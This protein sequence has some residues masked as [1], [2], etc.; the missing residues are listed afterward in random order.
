MFS[1]CSY[2]Q[3]TLNNTKTIGQASANQGTG[4]GLVVADTCIINGKAILN[5][6]L[7]LARPSNGSGSD[8]VLVWNS[9]DSLVKKVAPSSGGG[10]T[11]TDTLKNGWGILPLSFNGATSDTV[12]ADSATIAT[13]FVRD[14][15][16][17]A[18]GYYPYSSNPK[19]YL[20]SQSSDWSLTGNSGTV[21]GTNF[22][23]TTDVSL[24]I[25]SKNYVM[26]LDATT[27]YFQIQ[28]TL[29]NNWL[30][31]NGG[32]Y[33]MGLFDNHIQFI[34][35][36]KHAEITA[37]STAING[38][39][40]INDG[41][42]ANGY[43]YTSDVNGTGSWQP[44]SIPVTSVTATAPITSSGGTTPNINITKTGIDTVGTLIS[45]SIGSGFTA[46]DTARTNAV[47]NVVGTSPIT[48]GTSGKTKFIS[49]PNAA[50]D[51]TTKGAA[52]FN[53]TYFNTTSGVATIDAANGKA[54]TSQTGYMR[55]EIVPRNA[56]SL[57]ATGTFDV[58]SGTITSSVD[59]VVVINGYINITSGTGTLQTLEVTFTDE[60][61][62]THT[63]IPLQNTLTDGDYKAFTS[64]GIM[65]QATTTLTITADVTFV[66][67]GTF[68]V[69]IVI[70]G[71]R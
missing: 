48:V 19:G 17:I 47:S 27:D 14:K 58:F 66:T 70:Q 22:I 51:G 36:Q 39:L 28:D 55:A 1:A 44:P 65:V 16:S 4:N 64:G 54:T 49:I 30:I 63:T 32:N 40:R 12:I 42:Q 57:G 13:Y 26:T 3:T 29:G 62:N 50:A 24:N 71:S 23:G 38:L 5:S 15:D 31:G 61:S 33:L 41:T 53:A 25:K 52:A 46:I 60:T 68:D 9:T 8:S 2:G 69:G 37:D 45:G 10:G 11:T 7:K 18:G 67:T 34:G 35:S 56:D 21:P 43:I 20:T 59:N 6:T